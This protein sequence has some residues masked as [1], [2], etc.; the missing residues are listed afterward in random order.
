VNGVRVTPSVY[1]SLNDLDRLVEGLTEI[2]KLEPPT[3]RK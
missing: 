2:S 3:A 1:T